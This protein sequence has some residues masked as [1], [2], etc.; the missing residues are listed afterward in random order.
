MKKRL[1]SLLCVLAV[2]CGILSGCGAGSDSNPGLVESSWE[3]NFFREDY[4]E[5]YT[6]Y[7]QSLTVSK[8]TSEITVTGQTTSGKIDVRI[9]SGDGEEYNY[10][11]DG[12]M[13]EK[14]PLGWFHSM[15]WTAAVDLYE[16]TEGSFIIATR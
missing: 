13:D 10:C 2:T 14:I 8:D 15:E 11:I 1:W 5:K 7:E 16:D 9:T 3:M 12:V 4:D 6:H